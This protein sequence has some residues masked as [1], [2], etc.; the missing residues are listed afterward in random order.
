MNIQTLKLATWLAAL[1][2][3][4][5]LGYEVWDFLSR[6]AELEKY[7]DREVIKRTLEDE[8]DEPEPVK[9]D[10]VDVAIFNRIFHQ[11]DWTGRLPVENKP[12]AVTEEEEEEI[13]ETSVSDL[14]YILFIREDPVPG[15]SVAFVRFKEKELSRILNE[16]KERILRVGSRL[17]GS[18][19]HISVSAI[20][21][22]EGVTFAFDG[23]ERE[24]E[25]VQTKVFE[26]RSQIVQVGPDGAIMPEQISRIPMVGGEYTPFRRKE[27]VQVRQNEYLIGTEALETLDRDYSVILSR[28]LQYRTARNPVDGTVRGLQITRVV[29]NSLPAQHGVTEGEVLKSINGHTVKSVREAV[30][31]VKKEAPHTDEWVAV[32][33]KQGKEF[34]RTY[35]SPGR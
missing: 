29:P 23:D 13:P 25:T 19:S 12:V 9:D 5:T 2:V 26:G 7:V 27:T 30:V 35:R 11:M 6:R 17:V 14:L 33:E 8:V 1:A 24:P 22:A 10:R 16:P 3:G 31:F 21:I 4:G 28:D 20:S 34:T 32:F 15:E 18:Y